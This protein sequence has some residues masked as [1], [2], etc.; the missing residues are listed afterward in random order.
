MKTKIKILIVDDHPLVR[1]GLRAVLSAEDDLDVLGE[2]ENGSSAIRQSASLQPDVILMDLLM[3]EMNGGEAPRAIL[4]AKPEQKIIILT[5]VDGID[6]L[7]G[8][9]KAGALG[10]VSKNAPPS[11]L[12]EA[13]RAVHGGSI[14]LPSQIA[15]TLLHDAPALPPQVVPVDAITA[16]EQEVLN[17]ICK[18]LSNAEV[19]RKLLISPRTVSVH[20]SRMLNKLRLDNRTQLVLHAINTEFF[21]GRQSTSEN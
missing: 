8:A 18:G 7:R 4:T 11:E 3:P 13:I 16:R 6:I 20:V 15:R 17:L 14:V 5:S 1:E 12:I 21:H 9:I 19:A 2:A 10:Y